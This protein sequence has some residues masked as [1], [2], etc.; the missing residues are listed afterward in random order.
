MYTII[1]SGHFQQFSLQQAHSGLLGG[2]SLSAGNGSHFLLRAASFQHSPTHLA[3]AHGACLLHFEPISWQ[4]RIGRYCRSERLTSDSH[5]WVTICPRDGSIDGAPGVIVPNHLAG[6][7]FLS[8]C[9]TG[10]SPVG[11]VERASMPTDAQARLKSKARS[12]SS[13]DG[14]APAPHAG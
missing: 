13:E 12:P 4:N 5:R 1:S 6:F 7:F 8:V 14:F 10:A 3:T 2:P 11:T 9:A